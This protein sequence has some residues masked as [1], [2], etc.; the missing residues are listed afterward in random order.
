MLLP[1]YT[2]PHVVPLSPNFGRFWLKLDFVG[3][4]RGRS[5]PLHACRGLVVKGG[6]WSCRAMPR[7]ALLTMGPA[8]HVCGPLSTLLGCTCTVGQ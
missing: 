7:G 3:T 1:A 8:G 6:Y 2:Y 5:I 4:G